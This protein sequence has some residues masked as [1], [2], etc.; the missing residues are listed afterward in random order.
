MTPERPTPATPPR[1]VIRPITAADTRPLRRSILRPDQP[2]HDLVY[3]GDDAAESLHVGA[4]AG[5]RLLG[6]ASV[7]QQSPE[8]QPPSPHAWRLR[9]MAVVVEARRSG[10]GAA[11]LAACEENVRSGGG[12]RLWFNARIEALAFYRAL[13]Y[14]AIGEPYDLPGIGEHC[15]AER[16]F[17]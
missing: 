11:L 16:R 7:F 15:F 13:G 6:V 17:D 2:L 10:V 12:T 14:E 4:F 8:H 1:F 3:P 9:G 5:E